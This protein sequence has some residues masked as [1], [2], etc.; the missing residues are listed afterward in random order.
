MNKKFKIRNI[1]FLFIV[2]GFLAGCIQSENTEENVLAEELSDTEEI[3]RAVN[4]ELNIEAYVPRHDV[5]P[6]TLAII[7]YAFRLDDGEVVLTEPRQATITYQASTDELFEN[8]DVEAWEEENRS[9]VIYGEFYQGS[10]AIM[11]NIL[12]N[13]VGTLQEAEIREISGQEVQ[14]Q[15]IETDAESSV[16]MLFEAGEIGYFI[17]YLLIDGQTEEDAKIF[18]QEIIEYY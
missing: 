3:Q 6:A 7:E 17:I 9:E 1:S 4:E 13:G 2:A 15:L 12:P 11:M 16:M 10:A 5:Y 8:M 14:Y 18:V